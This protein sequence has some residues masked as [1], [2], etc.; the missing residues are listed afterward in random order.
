M[1]SPFRMLITGGAGTGKGHVKSIIKELLERA[2]I[3]TGN[4]CILMAPTGFATFNIGGLT[5]HWAPVEHGSS[6]TYRKLGAVRLK[7]LYNHG[8]MST[9]L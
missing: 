7:E 5:I 4:A 8:N 3:G 2:H 6:T 1:P 9:P